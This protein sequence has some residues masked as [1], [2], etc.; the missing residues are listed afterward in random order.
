MDSIATFTGLPVKEKAIFTFHCPFQDLLVEG[1]IT[2]L[3]TDFAIT[4]TNHL[5]E[6]YGVSKMANWWKCK[7]VKPS[8]DPFSTGEVIFKN[9]DEYITLFDGRKETRVPKGALKYLRLV[10]RMPNPD[11]DQIQHNYEHKYEHKK[12]TQPAW[13]HRT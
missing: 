2:P 7:V 10:G 4:G 6:N 12:D 8:D 3:G 11:S 5:E 13:D 9:G 1:K